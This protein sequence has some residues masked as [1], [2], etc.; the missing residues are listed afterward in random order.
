MTIKQKTVIISSVVVMLIVTAVI[1]TIAVLNGSGKDMAVNA[2]EDSKNYVRNAEYVK[3]VFNDEYYGAFEIHDREAI[4]EIDDMLMA[5]SYI[6]YGRNTTVPPGTNRMLTFVYA[7]GSEVSFSTRFLRYKDGSY[8]YPS[9]RD[10]LDYFLRTIGLEQG[11]LTE[12]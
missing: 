8:Y 4:N 6:K 5:R 2:F 1:I 10:N 11:K 3:V 9:E 7:D 12:R